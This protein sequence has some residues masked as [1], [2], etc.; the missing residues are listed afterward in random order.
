MPAD[1]VAVAELRALQ[2]R[3]LAALG[4]PLTGASRAR[5]PLPPRP[6]APSADFVRTADE[7]IAPS[8]TLAA[9]ARLELY[10]RQYW[11]RLLDS[12]AE[13]FPATRRL[14]GERA[15]WSV[16]EAYLEVTPP[17]G[18]TLRGLGAGLAD[19]L[20]ARPAMVRHPVHATD[21]A[22]LEHAYDAAFVA[23]AR[24][25]ATP[26][27]LASAPLALQPHVTLLALRTPA[28]RL[29]RDREEARRPRLR[30]PAGDAR[31]FVVV[32]RDALARQVERL[33]PV[34]YA[35]LATLHATGSLAAALDAAAPRL[36]ARGAPARIAAWF[37]Q[38]TRRGWL[39]RRDVVVDASC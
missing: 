23:A 9:P 21:L 11:Y 13:D 30:P 16:L 32:S 24:A 6:G 37:E 36:P 27:E 2:A 19:F 10:H 38:W 29:W 26:D 25:P 1:A 28:D 35:L 33:H 3:V 14:L 39:I 5:T 17:R 4:E 20:A 31:V 15:F 7:L 8:R 22:R 12:L 34:A 18:H